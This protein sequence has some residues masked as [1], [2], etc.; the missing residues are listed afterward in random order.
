[1]EMLFALVYI[2]GMFSGEHATD[3]VDGN[4]LAQELKK[5]KED[6]GVNYMQEHFNN[7]QYEIKSDT[8]TQ[9]LNR[10]QSSLDTS[11]NDLNLVLDN[12]NSKV[13]S[14]Y[15]STPDSQL[16]NL[17][18]CCDL[19]DTDVTYL[20][21]FQSKVDRSK[22]CVTTSPLAAN[23]L[24]YPTDQISDIMKNNYENN[25]NVLWQHYSTT[26]GVSVIY[27]AT[28]WD[29]CQNFD[30]RFKSSYAAAASP[31]D[32]DVVIV[33]DASSSMRQPSGVPAKTK[34]VIA[35]EAANN[36]LQT[37][38]PNDRVGIV[39][40]DKNAYTPTGGTYSSC[41]ENHLAFATKENTDKLKQ[42]MFSI[43]PGD[44]EPN[45]E[46]AL[47]S[48]F[49]YYNSSEEGV[50]LENREQVIL[51]ISD[52]ISSSG[53]NPVQVISD[54][55]SKYENKIAIFTY[56][57]GQEQNAKTQL[58]SMA[59]Q[60]LHNVSFGPKQIGNFE[61]FDQGNQK[62]LPT[63]LATFYV[64]LSTGSQSGQSTFTVPYVDPFSEVGLITSLCRRVHVSTGFHGVMCTDVK[65][66][67]LLTEIEYFSE[68]E[69]TYAFM[70]DGTGRALMHPLLPN[71]AFVNQHKTL[72]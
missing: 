6:I 8:G 64:H 2:F 24:K 21:E 62:F 29:N 11:L 48:A 71:A 46:N 14:V 52:G 72:F 36:V 34:I 9:L 4:K 15:S 61:Y 23:N 30:P 68:D 49:K 12:V 58:Q 37:L 31:T 55:N 19:Q 32:K 33:I 26:D 54:E 20:P 56:L 63:K 17:D 43:E 69:F 28:K 47:L 25:K 13:L 5:I 44:A 22:A 50:P 42:Y 38:K 39:R 27:P 40:F 45:F 66:S 51:F 67:K 60:D 3:S 16:T 57:L 70:I 1:M 35:K 65:I 59:N 18:R 7:F 10:I 53:S 41:Y